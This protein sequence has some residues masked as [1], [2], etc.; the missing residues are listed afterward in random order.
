MRDSSPSQMNRQLQFSAP[1]ADKLP[2]G[3][4]AGGRAAWPFTVLHR[5]EMGVAQNYS[6]AGSRIEAKSFVT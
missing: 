4:L 6:Q 5:Q 2:A 3:R 1:Y